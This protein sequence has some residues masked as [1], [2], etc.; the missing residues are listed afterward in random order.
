MNF[1]YTILADCQPAK[2]LVERN[3]KQPSPSTQAFLIFIIFIN[4]LACPFTAVMNALVMIAVKTKSRLRA[5][6]SN[7]L[8]A[9]LATT[10]FVVGVVVQPVFVVVM[11][12]FLLEEPS[13]H[14][15]LSFLMLVLTSLVKTSVFHLALI[16]GER[17]PAM[18]HPFA[19]TTIIAE[20]RLLV[21]SALAWL[22]SITVQI[23]Y[24]VSDRT[25][26]VHINIICVGLSIAF[27]VFCHITVYR[28]TRRHEQQIAAQQVTLEAR[29]QIEKDKKGF[30]LTSTILGCLLLCFI[31]IF[32]F[33][34]ISKVKYETKINMEA[35]LLFFYCL[36]Q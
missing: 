33:A 8:L 25:L 24:F 12:L 36:P 17:Y 21:C 20:A 29:E 18:K 7:M 26:L 16:T 6:K 4:I 19:Y 15:L 9:L 23:L 5:H 34:I 11:I 10:D 32:V 30:K 14:C 2:L 27:I 3:L 35:M 28:V 1:S 31:P 13:G 22:L